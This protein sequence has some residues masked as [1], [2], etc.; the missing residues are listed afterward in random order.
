[1]D[2]LLWKNRFGDLDEDTEHDN[3]FSVSSNEISSDDFDSDFI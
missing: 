3:D 1:M 2:D